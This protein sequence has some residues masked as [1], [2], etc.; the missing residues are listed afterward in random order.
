MQ[1]CAYRKLNS[2]EI[3]VKLSYESGSTCCRM[4][5]FLERQT[6]IN[7]NDIF[8]ANFI[9][10]SLCTNDVVNIGVVAAIKQCRELIKRRRGLFPT[11]K[12]I[13]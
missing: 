4:T 7:G 8:Q 11:L 2:K 6:K 13:G 9:V 12:A 10:Y 5:Q 1:A 3:N